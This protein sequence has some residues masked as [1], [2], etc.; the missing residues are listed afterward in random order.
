MNDRDLDGLAAQAW[1][2]GYPLVLMDVSR[3]V[4]TAHG[5]PANT[6]EHQRAF[7]DHTFTD[8]VTPNA[9][10]LYSSAWLDL[11]AEPV[12]LSMPDLTGRYHMMPMLSAWTDVFAAPGSRTSGEGGGEY[13]IC[14]PGWDGDLPAGVARVDAPTCLVW[15]VGQTSAAGT[16]DYL[17]VH[18][19]QNNMLLTPLSQYAD[20]GEPPRPVPP[21]ATTTEESTPVDQVARMDGPTFFGRLASLLADNPPAPADRAF[22]DSLGV[23]GLR[24]G[25]PLAESDPAAVSAMGA[26]PSLGQAELRR[27]GNEMR[28]DTVNGWSIQRGLGSY[29]TDYGRRA[30]VAF[31]GLG[32]NLD[33]DAIYPHATVDGEGRALNG[34]HQYVVHF[35][36]GALPPVNGFWSLTV[37]D[38][39]Q[40]FVDNPIDRYAIGDRD[41]LVY[42]EDGSLDIWIQHEDPGEEFSS[43]WLPAPSDSFNVFFRAYWPQRAALD[44]T[45]APPPVTRLV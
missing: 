44:G 17:A 5:G 34:G 20:G 21:L 39:K 1:I 30:H 27:L 42:G 10:T 43:N 22:V 36:A 29:G 14:P 40:F 35:D 13:A 8:V 3:Q 6:F 45:W 24:P 41:A 28:Q 7:P 18:A 15:L 38:D 19:L 16:K 25:Q 26:A 33:A 9:D 12:V 4:M 23:L 2:F 32:A 37:Y 31:Q 11:R